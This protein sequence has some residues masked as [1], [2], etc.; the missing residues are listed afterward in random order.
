MRY[1]SITWPSVCPD[2]ERNKRLVL[3]ADGDTYRSQY[4]RNGRRR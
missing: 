1:A 3:S 4:L 2:Y